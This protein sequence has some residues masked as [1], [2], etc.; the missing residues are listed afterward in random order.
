MTDTNRNPPELAEAIRLF[1]QL[2]PPE[3]LYAGTQP[4][5]A[6]VYTPWIAAWLLVYQRL[7]GNATLVEALAEWSQ[8]PPE[9]LPANKRTREHTVSAR[10]GTFSHA[11][12]RLDSAA[13]F[14][15]TDTVTQTLLDRQPGSWHGR[16]VFAIDGTTLALAPTSPLLKAYPPARNQ[17]GEAYRPTLLSVAAHD[18][19]TGVA[20]RPETGASYGPNAEG[21]VAISR[22]LLPR[23]PAKSLLLADRNF[24]IFAFAWHARLAQHD[25]ALRLTEARFQ[26]LVRSAVAVGAGTWKLDWRPTERDRKQTPELPANTHLPVYLNEIVVHETLTLWLVTSLRIPHAELAELYRLRGTIETDFR[27]LKR[28]LRL[29]EIRGQSVAMVHKEL[30]AATIAF[31]LIG[32]I[33]V[34]TAN[35][36]KITPR[37]LSFSRIATLVRILLLHVNLDDP[38]LVKQRIADVL[39]MAKQCVLPVRSGRSYPREAIPKVSRYP[40]RRRKPEPETRK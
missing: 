6:T 11:R 27:D 10:T 29:D 32:H 3:S 8:I 40:A 20:L 2:V 33:R 18:V 26:P 21:E 25:V 1:Q 31:N 9:L 39:R 34:L 22:R 13:L 35:R 17:H 30:A 16:R 23:L 14:A 5:A 37:R 36:M 38:V 15:A 24:G 7:A 12:Q 4:S 28:T 19:A